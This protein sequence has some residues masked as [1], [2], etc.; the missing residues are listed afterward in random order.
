MK[1]L[2]LGIFYVFL[3]LPSLAQL[4]VQNTQ[5]V[6]WYVEQILLGGGVQV[7]NVTFNGLPA[8]DVS[9]QVGYFNS[10][11]A[12]VGISSGMILACGEVVGAVGPNNTT[13][14]TFPD[15]GLNLSGDTDLD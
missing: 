12:N 14:S 6:Q 10:D 8:N 1:T 3:C 7:S 5:S 2:I 15:A 9:V 11:N 13:S 4:D